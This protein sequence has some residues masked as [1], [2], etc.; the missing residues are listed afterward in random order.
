METLTHPSP[1]LEAPAAAA[2]QHPCLN[3]GQAVPER[4][5]TRCGQDVHHTHRITLHHLLHDIPHSVWH[6][7][8]GIL[9]TVR[10][11]LRRPGS[12]IRRYLA[13]ERA[14][15]YRPLAL[16]LL[17]AGVYSLLVLALPIQLVA[18]RPAGASAQATQM[19]EAN[20]FAFKYMGWLC[21][22]MLP[23]FALGTWALLRR[24]RYNLAEHLT[25]HALVMGA[26]LALQVLSVPLLAGA[27]GTAA[28][29]PV[30]YVAALLLPAF[31]ML[32]FTQLATPAY[33]LPAALWRSG[34]AILVGFVLFSLFN[35]TV[36]EL[37]VGY[38][39][40]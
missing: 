12:T 18:P 31:Q 15:H 34:L 8:R 14:A 36:S 40:H 6:V 19:I 22:A 30:Y 21:V 11:T 17:L 38:H 10:E 9:F 1:P 2:A 35:S 33:R 7:D 5:C 23:V 24:L 13:G 20:R 29:K 27:S 16:V 26:A 32:A 4:F 28:F 25:A 39:G 37:A 3:C